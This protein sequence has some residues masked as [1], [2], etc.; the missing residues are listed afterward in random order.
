MAAATRDIQTLTA[1]WRVS[2][3]SRDFQ[4]VVTVD[5]SQV[6]S[7]SGSGAGETNDFYKTPALSLIHSVDLIVRT[8]GGATLTLD[9]GDEA[10]PDGWLDGVNG[11]ATANTRPALAGTEAYRALTAAGKYYHAATPLRLTTVNAN[12]VG[13]FDL[14]IRGTMIG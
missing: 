13:V 1:P 10:D 14:V 3:T 11:N 4:H 6:A 2:Q 9:V 5:L 8:A 12:A 7:G